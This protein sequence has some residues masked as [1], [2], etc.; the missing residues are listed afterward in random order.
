MKLIKENCL[1]CTK[2]HAIIS[3]RKT[4]RPNWGPP[5]SSLRQVDPLLNEASLGLCL[6]QQRYCA[7]QTGQDEFDGEAGENPSSWV[8]IHTS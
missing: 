6:S 2:V 4:C 5:V 3:L 8:I 7:W 1:S